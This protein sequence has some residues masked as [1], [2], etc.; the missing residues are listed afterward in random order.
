ME[1]TEL[2]PH[3]DY[4]IVSCMMA[5]KRPEAFGCVGQTGPISPNERNT[6]ARWLAWVSDQRLTGWTCSQCNWTY[7]VPALLSD[8]EAKKAFDRLASAKFQQHD[9]AAHEPPSTTPFSPTQSFELRA[10]KLVMQGFKPKDAAEIAMQEIIFENRSDSKVADRVKT[11]A[12]DF[13]RRVKS[14]LI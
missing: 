10:R 7:P 3:L 2:I 6:V 8:P 5:D 9:C 12:E 14:G 1:V 11:E 4:R 13:L